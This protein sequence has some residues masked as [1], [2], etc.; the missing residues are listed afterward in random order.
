MTSQNPAASVPAKAAPGLA[1]PEDPAE[2]GDAREHDGHP[3]QP[4]HD[5]RQVVVHRRQ[6][7]VERAADQLAVRV[8]LVGQPDEVVVDVAEVEDLVGVDEGE[9][10]VRELVEDLADRC[11]G[12]ADRD[13]LALQVEQPLERL[14]VALLDDRVLDEVDLVAELVHEREVAVD[15]VVA[16][17]PQEVI[18]AAGQ[19]RRQ[20]VAAEVVG[21]PRVPRGGVGR[22]QEPLAEDHVDLAR[23]DRVAVDERE[24]HDVDAVRG[25][26]DLRPLVALEDVLGDELVEAEQ[27]GDRRDLRPP[28]GR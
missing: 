22:Q 24:H 28:T 2:R 27:L 16:Q 26:L 20:P 3:G 17:R 12:A 7:D 6:V 11:R 15:Q 13:E 5:Q 18:G 1:H 25:D 8:E 14:R 4:L 21:R 9:V 23:H 19:D 10:A